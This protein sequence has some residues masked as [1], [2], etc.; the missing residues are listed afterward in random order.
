MVAICSSASEMSSLKSWMPM[1]LSMCQGGISR[2]T[3]R[4]LMERAQ[5]RTSA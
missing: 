3:T 1:F 4:F 2:A 5:G